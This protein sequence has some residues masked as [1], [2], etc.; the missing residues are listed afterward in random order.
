MTTHD[1][2]TRRVLAVASAGGHLMQL[3]RLAPAW[4]GCQVTYVTTEPGFRPEIE[5]EAAASGQPISGYY[6]VT[7][8]N[9]RQKLR[10]LRT[11]LQILWI[12]IRVRPHI[13]ITTGAAPGYFALRFGR[14][15]GART[16]WVDSIA[17]A[18]ELSLSGQKAGRHADLWLTQWKHL[19]QSNDTA[20][21]PDFRGAVL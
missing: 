20:K 11:L 10:L 12:V 17:N 4:Q 16:A 14:L 5:A 1:P 8:A 18:E 3:R 19:A 2:A 7:D 13:V 9:I 6:A 15:I 21:G